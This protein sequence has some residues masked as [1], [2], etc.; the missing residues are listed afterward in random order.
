MGGVSRAL[1]NPT[2]LFRGFELSYTL[3]IL[4]TCMH[5]SA[6]FGELKL[7]ISQLLAFTLQRPAGTSCFDPTKK[8]N[9]RFG[10]ISSTIWTRELYFMARLCEEFP[11]AVSE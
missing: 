6:R 4:D 10:E 1:G 11:N 5:E 8:R 2:L 3:L 7:L 9:D